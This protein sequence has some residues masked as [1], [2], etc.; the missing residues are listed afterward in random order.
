MVIDLFAD[1]DDI[2]VL[3]GDEQMQS[4]QVGSLEDEFVDEAHCELRQDG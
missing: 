1:H 3:M 4:T 2:G